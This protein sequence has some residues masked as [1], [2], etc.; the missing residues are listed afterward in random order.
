MRGS[1]MSDHASL[2]PMRR[3]TA[4]ENVADSAGNWPRFAPA[5]PTAKPFIA[6]G[7]QIKCRRGKCGQHV[8]LVD[9]PAVTDQHGAA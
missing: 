9:A 3:S 4:V 8:K 1:A 6:C 7:L 2:S 5:S